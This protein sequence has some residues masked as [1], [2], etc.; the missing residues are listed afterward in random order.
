MTINDAIN[1]LNNSKLDDQSTLETWILVQTK[2][3]L[4]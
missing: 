1:M 4:K 2:R 3:L